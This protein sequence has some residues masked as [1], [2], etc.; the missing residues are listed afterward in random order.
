MLGFLVDGKHIGKEKIAAF[1][2]APHLSASAIPRLRAPKKRA[3]I[4]PARQ[5]GCA[6]KRPG[7]LCEPMFRP[8]SFGILKLEF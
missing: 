3:T 4:K 8:F 6:Q 1:S 5:N 2:I 7:R